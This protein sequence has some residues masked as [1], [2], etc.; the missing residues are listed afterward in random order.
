MA[1]MFF[2]AFLFWSLPGFAQSSGSELKT[3]LSAIVQERDHEGELL[4][5]KAIEEKGKGLIVIEFS[6]GKR[7]S[8]GESFREEKGIG[9]ALAIIA[10]Q[11]LPESL[12]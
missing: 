1:F 11:S 2:F 5:I 7:R 8:L 4:E 3:I 10:G 9:E 12:K 6:N